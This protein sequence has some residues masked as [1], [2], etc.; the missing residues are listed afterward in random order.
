MLPGT[1]QLVVYKD[2]RAVRIAALLREHNGNRQKVADAL[3][4]SKTTLWRYMNKY[5]IDKDFSY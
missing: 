2:E 5:G 3:G 4:I 1:E